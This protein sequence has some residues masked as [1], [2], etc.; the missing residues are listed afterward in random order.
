MDDRIWCM[1]IADGVH[2]CPAMVQL[3]HRLKGD[4]LIVVSDALA[5]FG[6]PDGEYP[7]D[8]RP[9][10]VTQGTARLP[11]GTLA[12][13]TVSL[14]QAV[15]NLVDWGIYT[16]EQAIATTTT[17]PRNLLGITD[18]RDGDRVAADRWPDTP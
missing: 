10:Q 12:G 18:R 4:R 13:T 7:W 16:P 14:P 17:A 8:D 5:P 9:I 6:L 11:D 2:V 3:L 1:A 15:Q